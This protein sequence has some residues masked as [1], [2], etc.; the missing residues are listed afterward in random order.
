[1]FR[2]GRVRIHDRTLH[3]SRI[4]RHTATYGVDVMGVFAVFRPPVPA[5]SNAN[6]L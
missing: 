1:M 4:Q 5:R 6:F 2:S 3:G